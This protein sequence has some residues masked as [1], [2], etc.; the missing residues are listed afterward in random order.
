MGGG[1]GISCHG[2]HRIVGDSSIIAMPE[3]SIGLVPDVGGSYLLTRK[4]KKL[5]IY[6]G[7]SGQHM[8]ADDA[9]F[10]DFADFYIPEK[11]WNEIKLQLIKTG[12]TSILFEFQRK[13]L[14]SCLKENL[15]IIEKVFSQTKLNLIIQEMELDPFFSYSLKKIKNSSPLS[16]LTLSLI[17]I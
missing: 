2:S 4:S 15:Q 16:V 12:D 13:N 9:I 6:L 11:N 8:K 1:V 3:C 17:H 5:G 10:T 7:I 14:K